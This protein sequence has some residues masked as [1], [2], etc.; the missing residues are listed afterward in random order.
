M[1][2]KRWKDRDHVFNPPNITRLE[3]CITFEV[4]ETIPKNCKPLFKPRKQRRGK[5]KIIPVDTY[6]QEQ[7]GG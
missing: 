4:K 1:S 3:I 2:K 6:L 5:V 7:K